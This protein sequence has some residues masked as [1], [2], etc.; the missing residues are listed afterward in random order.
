MEG[1]VMD[2]RFV[3]GLMRVELARS[4]DWL[5]TPWVPTWAAGGND[6]GE[7]GCGGMAAES[8]LL[9]PWPPG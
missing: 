2:T 9:P 7:P 6:S 1:R 3:E 5:Q 4:G 8:W